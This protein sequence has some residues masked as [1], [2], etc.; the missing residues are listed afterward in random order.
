MAGRQADLG[1]QVNGISSDT[2]MRLTPGLNGRVLRS[3]VGA[4]VKERG[5]MSRPSPPEQV[6][7]LQ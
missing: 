2:L 6:R 7:E 5:C 4:G 1:R 3:V